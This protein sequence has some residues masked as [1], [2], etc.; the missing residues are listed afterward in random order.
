MGFYQ[1]LF[2]GEVVRAFPHIPDHARQGMQEPLV[3][4]AG[5]QCRASLSHTVYHISIT[6]RKITDFCAHKMP[7][8]GM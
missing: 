4:L 8:D 1:V 7:I 2:M 6:E 3:V 5:K